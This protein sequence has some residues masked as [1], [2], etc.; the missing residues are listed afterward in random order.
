MIGLEYSIFLLIAGIALILI[1]K[2]L[3]VESI[4]NTVLYIIGVLLF[5]VGIIFLLLNLL[6]PALFI[7]G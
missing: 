3:H 5:I 4:I 6:G 2:L 1:A 7:F